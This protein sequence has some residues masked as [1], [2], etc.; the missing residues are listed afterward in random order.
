MKQLKFK[1]ICI[2]LGS[3]CNFNCR[4]CMQH[5]GIK[6]EIKNSDSFD[7]I[8]EFIKTQNPNKLLLWGGEP[9]LYWD[10]FIELV[11]FARSVSKDMQIT[12]ITNGSLLNKD[13]VDF[14]N[15]YNIGIGLSNDAFAT[16]DTRY[17]DV[18][19]NQG[20]FDLYK[21]IKSKGINTVISAKTQDIYKVW[22]YYDKLFYPEFI[23][24]S[25]DVLK[26]FT[27]DK[28]LGSFDYDKF[29]ETMNKIKD[30]FVRSVINE[31]Y[32]SREFLFFL[33]YI[34]LAKNSDFKEGICHLKCGTMRSVIVIDFNGNIYK[35]KNSNDII[36]HINNLE[37]ARKNLNN[38]INIPAWCNDCKYKNICDT[39]GCVVETEDIKKENCE[40]NKIIYE[41]FYNGLDEILSILNSKHI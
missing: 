39:N 5:T 16:L 37:E 31:D 8:K 2:I 13:K 1:T 38:L 21:S 27:Q 30:G 40:V 32:N 33:N 24:V 6:S 41:A 12:T 26:N 7:A 14:I 11:L 19:K 9:L 35:C 15:K 3:N 10:K 20:I 34:T 17:N 29:R 22:E 23:N 4:Y 36:G 18:L 28:V 25:F